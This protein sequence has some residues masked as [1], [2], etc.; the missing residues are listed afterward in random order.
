M[1]GTPAT[2]DRNEIRRAYARRLRVTNPED[3]PDGFMALRAAYETAL[4]RCGGAASSDPPVAAVAPVEIVP[5]PPQASDP[6]AAAEPVAADP[7]NA[8]L[9]DFVA[10]QRSLAAQFGGPWRREAAHLA[11][12][13][14][15]LLAHPAMERIEVRAASEVWLAQLIAAN[16]PAADALIESTAA[17]FGWSRAASLRPPDPAVA[18]VLARMDVWQQVAWLARPDHSLHAGWLALTTTPSAAWR[19]RWRALRPSLPPQVETLL[20]KAP[21]GLGDYLDHD[22]VA[23]WTDYFA[24]PRVGL[25]IIAIVPGWLLLTA[26]LTYLLATAHPPLDEIWL[27]ALA[28][29]M[30]A[31][32]AAL[33]IAALRLILPTFRA[34]RAAPWTVPRWQRDGWMVA[35]LIVP[36]ALAMPPGDGLRMVAAVLAAAAVLTWQ[37]VASATW[38]ADQSAEWYRGLWPLWAGLVSGQALRGTSGMTLTIVGVLVGVGW[39]RGRD[40]LTTALTSV[41]PRFRFVIV[42]AAVLAFTA[43][44]IAIAALV[45]DVAMDRLG[46]AILPAFVV[47]AALFR[48]EPGGWRRRAAAGIWLG[49]MAVVLAGL[50]SL[51]PAPTNHASPEATAAAPDAAP[52]PA[53]RCPAVSPAVPG[54]PTLPIPCAPERWF[55]AGD[56]VAVDAA[57]AS[58]DAHVAVTI[59]PGGKV[60]ACEPASASDRAFATATCRMLTSRA[61]FLPARDIGN[62]PVV[63][64]T[65]ETIRWAA[66]PDL[67]GRYRP[68]GLA[69]PPPPPAYPVVPRRRGCPRD[70]G[71]TLGVARPPIACGDPVAWIMP[72]RFPTTAIHGATSQRLD[73]T[74][75]IDRDGRVAAC[76]VNASSGSPEFDVLACQ[77]LRNRGRF[78]PARNGDGSAATATYHGGMTWRIVHHVRSPSSQ[79]PG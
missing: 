24:Q 61:R 6:P 63:N 69:L 43:I 13:T 40:A 4:K 57:P 29:V 76:T 48:S 67:P 64:M 3:D 53:A 77:N 56:V 31:A 70:P 32:A 79:E 39:S 15:T 71:G 47:A 41:L 8:E 73:F 20:A 72:Q 36:I 30:A 5:P 28:A 49:L 75:S 58:A 27:E 23:W 55:D 17:F 42:I 26:A 54:A 59:D 25:G 62:R 37:F 12:L 74:L 45:P 65:T 52:P 60:T 11:E 35:L 7:A 2:R 14:A 34:W 50:V 38:R 18:A 78:M 1:L 21:R 46:L 22:A 19:Q 51:L 10:R 9:A 68:V 16:L 66:L 44:L 33:P